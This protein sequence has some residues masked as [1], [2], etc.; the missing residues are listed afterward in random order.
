MKVTDSAFF[1]NQN[2]NSDIAVWLTGAD[3]LCLRNL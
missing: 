1:R 3:L 2:Q